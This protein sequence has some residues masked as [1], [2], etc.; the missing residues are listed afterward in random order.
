MLGCCG[1]SRASSVSA[2]SDAAASYQRVPGSPFGVAI[3]PDGRYAFVDLV[4]GRVLVYSLASGNP[5]L[6]RT[7]AVPGE[8]VGCSITRDGRLLLVAD[9]QGAVVVSVARAERSAAHAVLGTLSPPATA[10][11]GAS[12]AIET[13][14]SAD[15]RYVFVSLEYGNPDGRIAVYGLGGGPVPRFGSADYVG[16]ITLGQAV[17][18]SALSP[19]GRYL[20]VTSELARGTAKLQADGTLSVIDV[21]RAERGAQRSILASVPA[22]H[23][24]VRVVVSPS[25]SI[26]WVT[27]RADNRVLAFAAARLLG[28]PRKALEA[29]AKVGTAPVGLATFDHGGRLI[30][31]DSNRFDSRGAHAGLTI[32]GTHA[33]IAHEP[34]TI[35]SPAAGLFPREIAVD[36]RDRIALVTN[37]GS[38]Q[39]ETIR[40]DHFR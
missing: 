34:A 11:L 13:A 8:A 9:G 36:G 24:P 18:G 40:L 28:D 17:V 35:A 12:G 3:T 6:V 4:Q 15:G 21:S 5:T 32:L 16:S 30:V 10:H 26:V 1:A 25:G 23:Q 20:Y 22:G 29:Q 14:S 27:A 37:F 38:S 19:N 39:L 7:I 2:G 33:V 31:A